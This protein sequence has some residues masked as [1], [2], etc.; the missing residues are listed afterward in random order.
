MQYYIMPGTIK[1]DGER[2]FLD[3]NELSQN[4]GLSLKDP[5]VKVVKRQSELI[6]AKGKAHILLPRDDGKYIC[7]V[8]GA[9]NVTGHV[10]ETH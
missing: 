9:P 3:A 10:H 8:C 6:L 5:N 2:F 1:I 4:Y 7:E